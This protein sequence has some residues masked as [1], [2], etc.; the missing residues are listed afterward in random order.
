MGHFTAY[1]FKITFYRLP[2]FILKADA[3]CWGFILIF[4]FNTDR[5]GLINFYFY[6]LPLTEGRLY[7]N[8][9]SNRLPLKPTPLTNF[10]R[11]HGHRISFFIFTDRLLF[12]TIL[13]MRTSYHPSFSQGTVTIT[14][15][16]FL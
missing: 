12:R 13:R 11:F 10:N 2:L 6:C 9:C 3:Y 7:F 16:P 8:S 15:L 1:R 4:N 5:W 14:A